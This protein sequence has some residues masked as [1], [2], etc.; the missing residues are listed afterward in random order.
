MCDNY[1]KNIF[2][3]THLYMN[4]IADSWMHILNTQYNNFLVNHL[5]H[6]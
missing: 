5:V 6:G 4:Q 1:M 2:Y 3:Y